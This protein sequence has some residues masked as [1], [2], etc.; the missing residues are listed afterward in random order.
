MQTFLTE[1]PS[2][3]EVE[4][5]AEIAVFN[6]KN[7]VNIVTDF[8][9]TN[10][11]VRKCIAEDI[12][13]DKLSNEFEIFTKLNI[14]KFIIVGDADASVNSNYLEHV[15]NNSENYCEIF[16]FKNCGHYA[17]LEKPNEFLLK[18]QRIAKKVF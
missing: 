5:A 4:T 9:Q 6:N 11:I 3:K 18:L 8:K 10:P 7:A 16:R 12:L 13:G 14:P 15:L 1:Q 17:S 2:L